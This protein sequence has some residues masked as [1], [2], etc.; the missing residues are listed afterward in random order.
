MKNDRRPL[1]LNLFQLHFPITAIISILHRIS[2]LFVFLM[3]PALLW[4]WQQSLSSES[5]FQKWQQ[6]FEHP[7]MKTGVTLFLLALAYHLLA[8]LRHLMMDCGWAETKKTAKITS[9]VVLFATLLVGMW[10]IRWLWGV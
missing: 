9:F 10:L 1:F 4:V 7:A 6:C 5:G 2:G 8:G 3:V